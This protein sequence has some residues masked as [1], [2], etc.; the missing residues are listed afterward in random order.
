MMDARAKPKSDADP[1]ML[2][3][4]TLVC[5]AW[6]VYFPSAQIRQEEIP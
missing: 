6:L 4:G 5:R 1:P 2:I 3:S